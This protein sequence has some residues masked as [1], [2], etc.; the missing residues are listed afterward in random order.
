[1]SHFVLAPL[2]YSPKSFLF[3]RVFLSSFHSLFF[4]F[5]QY[6]FPS[7]L[8]LFSSPYFP[9]GAHDLFFREDL[10]I[11][12]VF[13]LTRLPFA[14]IDWL[15]DFTRTPASHCLRNDC[16]YEKCPLLAMKCLSELLGKSH[17]GS[18]FLKIFSFKI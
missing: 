3:I 15:K 8:R 10:S 9:L 17:Y 11:I 4:H 2:F 1:M 16:F 13:L 18:S 5:H 7:T 12:L 6:S 14:F